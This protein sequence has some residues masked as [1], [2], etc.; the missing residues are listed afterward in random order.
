MWSQ[1]EQAAEDCAGGRDE[2]TRMWGEFLREFAPI[3]KSICWSEAGDSSE[4]DTIWKCI[5]QIP[6]LKKKLEK[7]ESKLDTY[8]VVAE[9]AVR[10]KAEC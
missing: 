9:E 4:A 6:Q 5:E 8:R 1:V 2:M 10:R 3:A 7:I